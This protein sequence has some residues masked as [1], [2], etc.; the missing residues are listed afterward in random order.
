MKNTKFNLLILVLCLFVY[1]C[2]NTNN[3]TINLTWEGGNNGFEIRVTEGQKFRIDW[4]DGTSTTEKGTGNCQ[5]ITHEYSNWGK[6]AVKIKGKRAS[7]QIT[8]FECR[9]N[10][11]TEL[12]LSKCTELEYLDC[13]NN[14]L[15][16]LMVNANTKLFNFYCLNNQ[17]SHL[18]LHANFMLRTLD[19]TKNKLSEL[20]LIFNKQLYQLDCSNNQL[21]VLELD[22]H[23]ELTFLKCHNNQLTNLDVR[24]SPRILSLDCSNNKLTDLKL[25]RGCSFLICS[26]NQLSDLDLRENRFL[27]LDRRNNCRKKSN[28]TIV[29]YYKN[30]NGSIPKILISTNES[31]KFI[32]PKKL[33]GRNTFMEVKKKRRII[34]QEYIKAREANYFIG[35]LNHSPKT[36]YVYAT[37]GVDYTVNDGSIKFKKQGDYTV[38]L[39]DYDQISDRYYSPEGIANVYVE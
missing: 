23:S 26:N 2:N 22:T 36:D 18:D 8:Y 38:L 13:S 39:T 9:N 21:T 33:K 34:T 35:M 12:D 28:L 25:N 6:Y 31:I 1:S 37:Q 14:L 27:E 7:C 32:I 4:G 5:Q 24:G 11:I 15:T 10:L 16:L 3:E 17:L 20:I 19:C 29:S 30:Q